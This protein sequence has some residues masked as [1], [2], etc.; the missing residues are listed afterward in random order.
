MP[1]SKDSI[2]LTDLQ[3][4]PSRAVRKARASKRPLVVT[5]RGRPRAV[6]LSLDLYEQGEKERQILRLLVRG[7]KEIAAGKGYDLD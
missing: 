3:E 7:E 5:E 6:L 1:K 4:D 2:P